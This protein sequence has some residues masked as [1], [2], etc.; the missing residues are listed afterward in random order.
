MTNRKPKTS[1]LSTKEKTG[2]CR[3][4]GKDGNLSLEHIIPKA[5]GGGR[6]IR[7]YNT[8]ELLESKN[9]AY[10]EIRQSGIAARTIC[11]DCNSRLG[12]WF[13]KDFSLFYT[14]LNLGIDSEVNKLITNSEIKNRC[15]LDGKSIKFRMEKMHLFY[16]AKR[17]LA[18]FCSID[19]PGLS[20]QIPEIRKALLQKD[21]VPNTSDFAIFLCLHCGDSDSFFADI[22]ALRL[23]N[24]IDC[25]AGVE[26]LY[27]GLYLKKKSKNENNL[28]KLGNCLNITNWLTDCEPN[29]EYSIDFTLP[30]S[31]SMALNIPV[32]KNSY[33]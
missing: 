20:E 5:A 19:F 8:T 29:R 13:D 22:A 27:V 16:I 14:V 31:K 33:D 2:I 23:P 17:I 10:G 26:S 7:L 24:T 18:I 6:K 1:I 9:E 25:Y 11:K 21:Y 32:P 30:F 4:C 28:D 15:E 12:R 3:I